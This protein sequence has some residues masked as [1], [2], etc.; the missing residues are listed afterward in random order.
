MEVLI[1]IR[2]AVLLVLMLPLF[3]NAGMNGLST[4]IN[5]DISECVSLDIS[6]PYPYKNLTLIDMSL[7]VKKVIGYCGCKS[8]MANIRIDGI[9]D[10]NFA[11]KEPRKIALV[12]SFDNTINNI[13]KE[14]MTLDIRCG[15]Y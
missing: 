10:E 13:Q 3:V 15:S 6:K 2:Y 12:T 5:N 11:V 1:S 9:L 8:A 4:V 14:N 7:D